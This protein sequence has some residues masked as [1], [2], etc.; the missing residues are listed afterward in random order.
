MISTD[1][2][3]W[4][5]AFMTICSFTL[6]YGDNIL[7]RIGEYTFT[8][9][10]VAHSVVT[11]VPSLQSR[12]T[13]LWTFLTNPGAKGADPW[14]IIPFI[15]GIMAVFVVWRKYAWVASFPYAMFIGVATGTTLRGAVSATL[16]GNIKAVINEGGKLLIGN[17][18]DQLGY[19]VRI[20]FTISGLVYLFFTLF[21]KGPLNKPIEYIR[22]FGK[23][24]WLIYMG[25]AIGNGVQQYSGLATSAM[26]RLIRQWLGF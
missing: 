11:A 16:L 1:P 8:S 22:T 18:A 10:V 6:L 14:Y 5:S 23:Y 17:P 21:H 4:L 25:L 3:V 9:V 13:P 2:W 24:A 26:N 15:L 19:A 20:I 12:F 7:F